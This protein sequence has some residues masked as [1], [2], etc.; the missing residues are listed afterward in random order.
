MKN[1]ILLIISI[2]NMLIFLP[3]INSIEFSN[4]WISIMSPIAVLAVAL[5]NYSCRKKFENTANLKAF[6][7]FFSALIIFLIGLECCAYLDYT[8]QGMM[9]VYNLLGMG[10]LLIYS[11]TLFKNLK[12]N[13]FFGVVTR[14]TLSSEEIWNK[15]HVFSAKMQITGGALILMLGILLLFRYEPFDP[16]TVLLI[17][18][19]LST[20]IPII[21]SKIISQR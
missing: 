10:L 15:T 20:Y 2:L 13:K 12:Q 21:Y 19:L 17:I 1:K 7:C 5:Y 14:Y 8:Y 9:T 11:G 3:L 6:N 16:Y 18:S 4:K